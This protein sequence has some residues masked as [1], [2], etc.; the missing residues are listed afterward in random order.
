MSQ[1]IFK[2]P[3]NDST[4]DIC[5]G[6]RTYI[7]RNKSVGG[8]E[9]YLASPPHTSQERTVTTYKKRR[10]QEYKWF[11]SPV[12]TGGGEGG[13]CTHLD[14]RKLPS[15]YRLENTLPLISSLLVTNSASENN[16]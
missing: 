5:T 6:T 14:S 3:E 13:G 7:H 15:I 9:G 11:R 16:Q 2:K 1:Q 4:V 8:W 10:Q 12:D